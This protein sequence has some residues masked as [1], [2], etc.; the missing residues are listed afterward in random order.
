MV[1][2]VGRQSEAV[3]S[4]K[5]KAVIF[6]IGGLMLAVA[7]LS[8]C[9]TP[10]KIPEA[11]VEWERATGNTPSGMVRCFYAPPELTAQMIDDLE[12]VALPVRGLRRMGNGMMSVGFTDGAGRWLPTLECGGYLIVEGKEGQGYQ[13][14]VKNETD[15]PLEILPSADGL[16]LETGEGA[17]LGRA[18]RIVAPRATTVFS[19]QTSSVSKPVP[20][21]FREI[22]STHALLQITPSGTLGAVQVL[23]F[24]R[25]G[26]D[27]FEVRSMRERRLPRAATTGAPQRRSEPVLPPYQY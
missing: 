3:G 12:D 18:G 17:E 11:N 23:A 5:V 1:R 10:K 7:A 25:A 16:D 14:V 20:L 24:L 13:V 6:R 15:V 4:S 26:Q 27:S 9:T 8:A 19:S 22:N 2:Q 21:V